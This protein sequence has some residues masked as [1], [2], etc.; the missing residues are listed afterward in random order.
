VWVAL[1]VGSR[2]CK[3]K[4]IYENYPKEIPPTLRAGTVRNPPF[5]IAYRAGNI[6][7][8]YWYRYNAI[9]YEKQLGAPL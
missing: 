3:H 7:F 6:Y 8:M 4:K 1:P 5:F 9:L 2:N